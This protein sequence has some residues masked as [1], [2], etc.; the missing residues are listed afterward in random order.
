MAKKAKA[1]NVGA[2]QLPQ[3]NAPPP[4]PQ[5][6]EP[7]NGAL[8]PADASLWVLIAGLVILGITL[9]FF[10]VLVIISITLHEVPCGSRFLVVVVFA[11]ATGIGSAFLGSYATMRGAIPLPGVPQNPLGFGI[12]GGIAVIAVIILICYYT[13]VK[14]CEPETCQ[15]KEEIANGT[16]VSGTKKKIELT[17]ESEKHPNREEIL[18]LIRDLKQLNQTAEERQRG[19]DAKVYAYQS[20]PFSCKTIAYKVKSTTFHGLK[21]AGMQQSVYLF[22][23]GVL[24]N[25]HLERGVN[26]DLTLDLPVSE[27]GDYVLVF[28]L[29]WAEKGTLPD[30]GSLRFNV[31]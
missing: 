9:L 29:V 2:G 17:E 8:R 26:E 24:E 3:G 11:L 4:P 16:T 20:K 28:L 7:A 5:P 15:P 10:M 18:T 22:R 27:N 1:A 31:E 12:G 23:N 21:I 30:H 6:I 13:Y 19:F 14:R 25:R